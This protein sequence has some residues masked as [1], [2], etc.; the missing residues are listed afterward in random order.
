MKR[1][2]WWASPEGDHGELVALDG[3]VTL[4][5]WTGGG[6]T[7]TRARWRLSG[8]GATLAWVDVGQA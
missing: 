7:S 2:Q 4:E 8:S 6:F 3:P 5:L 1:W